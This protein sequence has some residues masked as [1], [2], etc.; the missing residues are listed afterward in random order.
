[1]FIE[2]KVKNAM[3]IEIKTLIAAYDDQDMIADHLAY[4]N[5]DDWDIDDVKVGYEPMGFPHDLGDNVSCIPIGEI[6]IC[7]LFKPMSKKRAEYLSRHTDYIF[8]PDGTIIVY[9]GYDCITLTK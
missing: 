6:E 1:M 5:L 4:Y 3:D 2:N 8:K 7:N 9:M